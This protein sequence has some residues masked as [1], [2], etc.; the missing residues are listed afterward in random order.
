MKTILYNCKAQHECPCCSSEQLTGELRITG[1]GGINEGCPCECA[2]KCPCPMDEY[3]LVSQLPD[4][5]KYATIAY[6]QN[7]IRKAINQLR[8]ELLSAAA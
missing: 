5:D 3:A 6:V 1:T 8:Q 2:C 4:M 7:E